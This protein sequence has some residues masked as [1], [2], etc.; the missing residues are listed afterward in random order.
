MGLASPLKTGPKAKAAALQAVSLDD[1]STE[2]HEA[3][4]WN[5][6]WREWDWI[7]AE[8]EWRRPSSSTPNGTNAR[9]LSHFLAN[10][11]R[12]DEAAPHIELALKLDPS[13]ALFRSLY[14]SV[15]MYSG[16]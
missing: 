10:V 7:G 9:A 2:A 11:G 15:L 14:A 3:L 6:T 16:R 1:S 12:I 5:K 4:A 8:P 13:N